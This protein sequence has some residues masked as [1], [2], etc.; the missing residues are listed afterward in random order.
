MRI[1]GQDRNKQKIDL[2]QQRLLIAMHNV[3]QQH[4]TRVFAV[5]F[6]TVDAGLHQQ[7]RPAAFSFILANQFWLHAGLD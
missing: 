2:R 1:D 7:G 6:T 3:A 4:Q 5:N